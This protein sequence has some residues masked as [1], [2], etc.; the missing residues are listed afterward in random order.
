[1]PPIL[2]LARR[3]SKPDP[4]GHPRS[5]TVSSSRLTREDLKFAAAINGW[6]PPARPQ[7]RGDCVGGPRPCPLVGCAHNLYLDVMEA[8]SIKFNRPDLDPWD[9]PPDCS[10]ALDVADEG[11]H[12]LE[13]VAAIVNMTRER[14]RQVETITLRKLREGLP[15]D[16]EITE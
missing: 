8:G 2:A 9:V 14:V 5:A 12:T 10:C 16:L 11:G 13:R 4:R 7:V 3:R 1:M 6:S 15:A